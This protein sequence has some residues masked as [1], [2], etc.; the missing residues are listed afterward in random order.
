MKIGILGAGN[1]GTGIAKHLVIHKHQVFLSF[2]RDT[3]KMTAF[4]DSIGAQSGTANEAARFSDVVVLAAPWT[5]AAVALGQAGSL[6]GKIIWDCTNPLKPDLSGLMLGTTTSAG[7]EV[8]RMAPAARVVK[9]IPPFAEMLHGAPIPPGTQKPATFVCGDDAAA[10]RI[11]SEL[12]E[13]IGAEAVDT[14]PLSAARFAEPMGMLLVQL[15]YKQGLGGRI[16]AVL[17]KFG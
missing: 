7:E 8:A 17:V 5:A 12:V 2:A 15:A 14:G 13:L 4:A 1:L 16:G 3:T 6:D 11:V 9:A 10:K